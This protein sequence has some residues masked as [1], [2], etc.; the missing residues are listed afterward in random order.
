MHA[1]V[2]MVDINDADPALKALGD[3][4]IPMVK[5]APGFVAGYW[6][7]L[8]Q[9]HGMSVVVLETEEQARAAAPRVGGRDPGVTFTSVKVGEVVGHA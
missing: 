9:D 3:Q 8:D 6:V 1:I 5:Q 4:V 2:A 7:R